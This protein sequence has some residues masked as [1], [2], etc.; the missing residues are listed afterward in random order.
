MQKT[1]IHSHSV[2]YDPADIYGHEYLCQKLD[3]KAAQVLFLQAKEHGSAAFQTAG[4]HDY[5]LVHNSDGTYTIAK[6]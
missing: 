6:R 1:E 3:E 5:S 4:G 2:F